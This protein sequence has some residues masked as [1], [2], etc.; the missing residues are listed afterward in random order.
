[1]EKSYNCPTCF[2]H[3]VVT[4][5]VAVFD[6]YGFTNP[7]SSF[8]LLYPLVTACTGI[9]NS[10]LVTSCPSA[11]YASVGYITSKLNSVYL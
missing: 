8:G 2:L 11:V 4:I 9:A 5:P 6:T 3:V 7:S 10:K 1:M